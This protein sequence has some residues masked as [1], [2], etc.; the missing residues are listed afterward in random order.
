MICFW[1]NQQIGHRGMRLVDVVFDCE[2]DRF[3]LVAKLTR[4]EP[5]LQFAALAIRFFSCWMS[6]SNSGKDRVAFSASRRLSVRCFMSI[7]PCSFVISSTEQYPSVV[8]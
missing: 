8:G 2:R 7:I 4:D 1:M 5:L 6:F 3:F